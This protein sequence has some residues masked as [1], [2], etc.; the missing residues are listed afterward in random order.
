MMAEAPP[1]PLQMPAAPSRAPF[2]LSTESRV[3]TMRAPLQPIGWPMETAPPLT[4]TLA[5]SRPSSWLLASETTENAWL[6]GPVRVM[7]GAGA[8]AASPC[9]GLVREASPR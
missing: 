4:L 3:T 6:W 2:C 1:P 8:R 7:V 9:Q 5:G